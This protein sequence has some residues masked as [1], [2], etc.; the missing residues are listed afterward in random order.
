[1]LDFRVD[2][3]LTVCQTMNF[4][5]AAEILHITQPA[6]SQ[7]IKALEAQYGTKLFTYVGKQ[8]ALTEAG[9]LF[10]QTA[11]TIHHDD[12]HLRDAIQQLRKTRR[13]NFGA[14]L[15]IGQYVM[16]AALIRLLNKEPETQLRMIM[17]NTEKL[18]ALLDQGE[19][20][21][22]LVEGFFSQQCYESLSYGRESYIPVCASEYQ[23][24]QPVRRIEDLLGERLLVREPGSGTREVLERALEE[25]HLS[26]QD[27]HLLT[28][29]GSL[30]VIK[31]LVCAGV[32]I[33]FFYFPV[34]KAQL[35]EGCL[36]EIPLENCTITHDFHFIW[37]KDSVFGTYYQQVFQMLK[38]E[39]RG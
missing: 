12:C 9:K 36:R 13:L 29:L 22:A 5:R 18:L 6:V 19:I 35:E 2:T 8:L 25:H 38:G 11:I 39:E 14:T 3:F 4:T 27:F 31:T 1:M 16:P 34:V 28:E 23:F 26:L 17:G 30:D 7:H 24:C 15:T 32:G 20:D 33:S 21:F 10:L 37:R